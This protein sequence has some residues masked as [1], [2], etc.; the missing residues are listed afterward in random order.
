MNATFKNKNKG[1][2]V[3]STLKYTTSESKT[4]HRISLGENLNSN[5][6]PGTANENLVSSPKVTT[7]QK[8][9]F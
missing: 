5:F 7:Q 3:R 2:V 1:S 4:D 9:D 8:N 6:K